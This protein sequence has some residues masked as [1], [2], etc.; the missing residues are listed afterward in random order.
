MVNSG[1][2]LM[3]HYYGMPSMCGGL[4]SD[5]KQLDAQAGAEKV[6]TALPLI[7]EGANIIYGVGATDAGSS[8]SYSQMILDNEIIAGLSRLTEGF[9]DQDV[10]QEVALIKANTPRGNFLKEDHTRQNYRQ[11]WQP[12]LFNREA[13][14]TWQEKGTTIESLCRQKARDILASHQPLAL[15]GA[16]EAEIERILRRYLG[17]E[18]SLAR[19]EKEAIY[20]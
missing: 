11:H 7:K 19:E 2:A 17:P 20:S 4:S 10:E 13:Y 1:A 12:E 8:I 18:F 9:G 14:E 3:G 16:V 6:L 5:A 15:S